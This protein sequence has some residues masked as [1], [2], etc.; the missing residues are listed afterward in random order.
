[1]NTTRCTRLASCLLVAAA[2]GLAGGG[3]A[4][5]EDDTAALRAK[6]ETELEKRA[7][8]TDE[9][10]GTQL[11]VLVDFAS[12]PEEKRKKYSLASYCS[13][14]LHKLRALCRGPA[15][16]KYITKK[17]K[18]YLCQHAKKAGRSLS[19][20]KGILTFEIDFEA[21]NNG[22]FAQRELVRKL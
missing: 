11:D 20:K 8:R 2:L 22:Q 4:R 13:E 6:V 1:M 18:A 9:A 21:K 12:F 5:A 19:I 17:V 3:F 10:C 16:K 14:P 7:K 15:T